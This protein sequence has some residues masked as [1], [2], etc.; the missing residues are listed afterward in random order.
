L[1]DAD[2]ETQ[3]IQR[4]GKDWSAA[5]IQPDR[6]VLVAEN[7][8]GRI[9]GVAECEHEPELGGRP[10]LQMLYVVPSASGTGAATEL[11]HAALAAVHDAGHRSTWLEV[12]A[13]QVRARCFYEREGFVQDQT[14]EPGSN[15]LVEL[16]HY[17][18][19][20][21]AAVPEE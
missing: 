16:L 1:S 12:V 14:M 17:R 20:Q 9:V 8:D 4:S 3:A 15:G 19:D 2:I 11:L 7:D 5:L 6:V 10:W 13:K 21:P 18:H